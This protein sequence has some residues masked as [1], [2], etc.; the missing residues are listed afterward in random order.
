[1]KKIFLI[2][3]SA[4]MLMMCGCEEDKQKTD[5]ALNEPQSMFIEG[6]CIV[7]ENGQY[8]IV[9]DEKNPIVMGSNNK[10]VFENLTTGDIIKIE[11][12]VIMESYPAQTTILDLEF[13]KDGKPEDISEELLTNLEGM[14]WI[15]VME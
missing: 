10:S 6:P 8:M 5:K 1:M 11:C 3:M 14:G 4:F 7:L 15:A 12:K 2:F 13:I 9:K